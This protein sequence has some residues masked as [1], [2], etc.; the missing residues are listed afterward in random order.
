[1]VGYE[2]YLISVFITFTENIRSRKSQGGCTSKITPI[3]VIKTIMCISETPVL[4][5]KTLQNCLMLNSAEHE[6]HVHQS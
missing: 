6:I 2:N 3:P 1:M 4:L 5:H